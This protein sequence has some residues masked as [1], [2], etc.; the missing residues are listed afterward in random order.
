MSQM[1]AVAFV[2]ANETNVTTLVDTRIYDGRRPQGSTVPALVLSTIT[3]RREHDLGG[4]SGMVKHLVVVE[5]FAA[6]T[7]GA[8]ALAQAVGNTLGGF[9]GDAGG[10]FINGVEWDDE[11]SSIGDQQNAADED[12][13]VRTLDFLVCVTE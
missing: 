11:R 13:H 6:D 12:L 3:G 7:T 5:C 1:A 8:D 10:T 9:R 2:L 4:L